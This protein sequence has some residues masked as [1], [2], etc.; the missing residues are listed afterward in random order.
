M[1]KDSLLK[2]SVHEPVGRKPL[3]HHPGW[4]LPA[5]IQHIANDVRES[6][7]SE[8]HAIA[9]AVSAVKKWSVGGKKVDSNTR[10]AARKAVAE[11]EAEKARAHASTSVHRPGRH[12]QDRTK[13]RRA[14]G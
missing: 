1:A 12:T 11:W 10:A 3:W 4:Q 7:K 6:G 9:I 8:S 14:R 13:S 2:A 5:Y